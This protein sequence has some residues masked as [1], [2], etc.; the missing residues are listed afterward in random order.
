MKLLAN[1]YELDSVAGRGGT[2]VVYKAYDLQAE[3]AVRA[4]KEISKSNP[5]AYEMAKRESQLIKELYERDTSYGRRTPRHRQEN[6]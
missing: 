5:D 1:R 3:R 6:T 4:I 2:S